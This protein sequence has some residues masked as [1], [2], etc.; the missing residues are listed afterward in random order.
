VLALLIGSLALNCVVLGIVAGAM[1]RFRSPPPWA[2]SVT[3]NLLGYASALPH[4]RRRALWDVTADERRQVRP[5]RREVRQAREDT[6]RMLVADP[7]DKQ[8]FVGAQQRQA[9]AENR[10]RAAVQSLYAEIAV[11]LT[12]AERK[13]FPN[14]R[15]ARRPPGSNL[16]DEPE[17]GDKAQ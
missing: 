13:A 14:W 3:P 16:L 1:W 5:F 2:G 11:N 9:E 6:L 12:P 7:F 8:R 4:D 10:A 15:D 17:Q